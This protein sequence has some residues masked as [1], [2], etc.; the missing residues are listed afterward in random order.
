MKVFSS[1]FR[2]YFCF[3]RFL[4][5]LQAVGISEVRKTSQTGISGLMEIATSLECAERRVS[6]INHHSAA[7]LKMLNDIKI[8]D[9]LRTDASSL[10]VLIGEFNLFSSL[11]QRAERYRDSTSPVCDQN[12]TEPDRVQVWQ[13]VNLIS[14]FF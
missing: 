7:C 3:I 12:I 8:E 9:R 2:N 6:A 14:F 5:L 10:D 1:D 11:R 13:S 4:P